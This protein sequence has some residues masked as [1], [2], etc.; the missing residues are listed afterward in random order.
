VGSGPRRRRAQSSSCRYGYVGGGGVVADAAVE[1][2]AGLATPPCGAVEGAAIADGLTEVPAAERDSP[3]AETPGMGALGPTLMGLD[4]A[5][6]VAAVPAAAVLA[7]AAGAVP[8]GVGGADNV[9][10][11]GVPD[12]VRMSGVGV[13]GAAGVDGAAC[14][15]DEAA[16]GVARVKLLEPSPPPV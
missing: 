8:D 5:A 7:L 9:A 1:L 6:A 2:V 13:L 16:P 4:G 3:T 12:G 15:G 11:A 14:E 10:A